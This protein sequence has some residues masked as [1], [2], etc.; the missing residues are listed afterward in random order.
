MAGDLYSIVP[1]TSYT[2]MKNAD[3]TRIHRENINRIGLCRPLLEIKVPIVLSTSMLRHATW[4][5][6]LCPFIVAES[7]G[8][9]CLHAERFALLSLPLPS[10]NQAQAVDASQS[11][12]RPCMGNNGK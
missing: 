8:P 11:P 2:H 1:I 4:V 9:D 3:K 7:D 10:K 5:A 12:M 6:T